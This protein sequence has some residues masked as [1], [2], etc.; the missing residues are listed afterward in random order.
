M[1]D[2]IEATHVE[3]T[4][5]LEN[6]TL[7]HFAWETPVPFG[8]ALAQGVTWAKRELRAKKIEGRSKIERVKS[9]VHRTHREWR[10]D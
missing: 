2:L 4:L 1:A 7:H 8:R 3:V 5:E 10:A 9:V 6:G